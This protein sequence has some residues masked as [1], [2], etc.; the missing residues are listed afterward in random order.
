MSDIE[1]LKF[2]YAQDVALVGED[3]APKRWLI[4]F[5]SKAFRAAPKGASPNR[6]PSLKWKR[7]P[8]AP[9]LPSMDWLDAPDWA[10]YLNCD[11]GVWHSRI[12]GMAFY[13][14]EER[15]PKAWFDLMR[16][17][18]EDE[19]TNCVV[20]GKSD[21]PP[22]DRGDGSY[23]EPI[24]EHCESEHYGTAEPA[25]DGVLTGAERHQA[26]ADSM[27]SGGGP[28]D[29]EIQRGSQGWESVSGWPAIYLA[30]SH[31]SQV[32]RKPAQ[33]MRYLID[34]E[35]RRWEFP[36]PMG[37]VPPSNTKYWCVF[38]CD[39]HEPDEPRISDGLTHGTT[40]AFIDQGRCHATREARDAHERA[41]IAASKGGK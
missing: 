18:R 19:D 23:D 3:E 22:A 21:T 13:K 6:M 16:A 29:F 38:D 11:T 10:K 24:C 4:G 39:R 37:Q 5:R 35:G 32:R 20:C 15:P 14:F 31:G 33:P 36:E 27:N 17:E 8:E 7:N 25:D 9:P 2:Q 28:L 34:A 30:M 41:L 12:D 26:F 1:E 40:R